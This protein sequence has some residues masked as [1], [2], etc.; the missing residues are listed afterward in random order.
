MNVSRWI[1]LSSVLSIIQNK[2]WS[3]VRNSACKYINLRI[4]TRDFKCLLS[5]RDDQEITLEDLSRQLE[6]TN[7]E[8][9]LT[10]CSKNFFVG[11]DS[12]SEDNHG[13]ATIFYKSFPFVRTWK[14]PVGHLPKRNEGKWT[15]NR[16]DLAL[17]HD[18]PVLDNDFDTIHDLLDFCESWAEENMKD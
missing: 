11:F 12:T 17:K 3:W 15:I 14:N 7:V 6:K 1:T 2:N 4:D 8:S 18:F 13:R 16:D 5:N 10:I 9:K